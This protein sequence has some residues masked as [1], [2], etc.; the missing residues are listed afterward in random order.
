MIIKM[1]EYFLLI[2][3]EFIQINRKCVI[4]IKPNGYSICYKNSREMW[5]IYNFIL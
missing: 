5:Q 3:F 2:L 4:N 1:R